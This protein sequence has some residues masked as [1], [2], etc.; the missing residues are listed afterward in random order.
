MAP[1]FG[2]APA[3]NGGTH[4]IGRSKSCSGQLSFNAT[5]EAA[6]WKASVRMRGP[7]KKEKNS[8][9]ALTVLAKE[10]ATFSL[11]SADKG[12]YVMRVTQSTDL[13]G[14]AG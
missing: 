9:F 13:P 2:Q 8:P 3:G 14:G 1:L 11:E 5:D 4:R 10:N 12:T 6:E 7:S